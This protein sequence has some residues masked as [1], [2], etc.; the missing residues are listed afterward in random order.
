M[1]MKLVIACVF[2]FFA[3]QSYSQFTFSVSPGLNMNRAS[4]GFKKGRVNPFMGVQFFSTSGSYEYEHEVFDY[5]VNAIVDHNHSDVAKFNLIMPNIGIKYFLKDEGDLRAHF[6]L[7]VVKPI[8][9]AKYENDGVE[10]ENYGDYVKS[11]KIWGGEFSFGAEYF[12][13][14]QFSIGGEF[15]LRFMRLNYKDEQETTVYNPIDGSNVASTSTYDMK[16][17]MSPTFSK[18]SLNFY[19]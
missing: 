18:I 3:Q 8:M 17:N 14:E 13:A 15:G 11:L 4:F 2:A 19:F 7:N 1:K 12:F 10:D 9:S 16:L 5:D 6:T